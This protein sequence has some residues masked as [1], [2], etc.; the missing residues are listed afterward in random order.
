M[1]P[2]SPPR[3]AIR[4]GLVAAVCLLL[5]VGAA[6]AAARRWASAS[7]APASPAPRSPEPRQAGGREASGPGFEVLTL[8]PNGFEP[9]EI[10]RPRGPFILRVAN[11]TGLAELDLRLSREAGGAE[12]PIR[13]RRSRPDRNEE[14]DL[15]PGRYVL[16]EAGR[17]DWAC[18]I[19]ITPHE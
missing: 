15:E 16:S 4:T 8:T 9:G 14:L 18:R 5:A 3:F 11:R 19:T 7:R 6:G 1:P 2:I 17:P 10:S 13:V 12:R